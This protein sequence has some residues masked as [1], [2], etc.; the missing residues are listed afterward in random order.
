MLI[1]KDVPGV[2]QLDRRQEVQSILIRTSPAQDAAMQAI[3]ALALGKARTH[4][5]YSRNCTI[6]VEEVS[7]AGGLQVPNTFLPK[8]LFYQL[9]LTCGESQFDLFPDFPVIFP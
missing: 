9:Q 7:R 2:V 1:G 6:F 8:A 4:N 3:I 5:L